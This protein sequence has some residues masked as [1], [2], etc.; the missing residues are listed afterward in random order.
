MTFAAVI[1]LEL[2]PKP[3]DWCSSP[4]G[5]QLNSPVHC[6]RWRNGLW[7]RLLAV[8]YLSLCF[9]SPVLLLRVLD[10][11]HS[12]RNVFENTDGTW[13]E[14]L[15]LLYSKVLKYSNLSVH[16]LIV[17]VSRSAFISCW[18]PFT[19]D[20]WFL[21]EC[22]HRVMMLLSFFKEGFRHLHCGDD[23]WIG[24]LN[25]LWMKCNVCRALCRPAS[26]SPL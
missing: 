3:R 14:D 22:F 11:N 9:M 7:L 6:H 2:D 26:S 1:H 23:P 17:P 8:I 25:D 15:I 21:A 13:Y 5:A 12:S 10:H 16:F 20:M 18:L 4:T 24:L 19:S